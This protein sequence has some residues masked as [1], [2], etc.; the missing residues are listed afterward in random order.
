MQAVQHFHLE[1]RHATV[2]TYVVSY[3][4]PLLL[5]HGL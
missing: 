4:F 1:L 5:V 2:P 3:L